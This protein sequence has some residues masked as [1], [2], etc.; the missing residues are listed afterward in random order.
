MN[1]QLER[2]T[3][4]KKFVLQ[5]LLE[6]YHYDSSEYND[7]KLNEFGLFGYKYLDHYWTEE[8][9]HPFFI[10]CDDQLAG[11]VLVRIFSENE[12]IIHSIAEFFVMRKFRRKGIGKIAAFM[13][14]DQFSGI[15]NVGQEPQNVRAQRFWRTIIKQYSNNH[16]TE[17]QKKYWDGPMQEFIS[18]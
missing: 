9:R 5:N 14:F 2:I 18:K 4:E 7:D 13:V 8:G 10:K 1:I 6:L 15:W 11:F 16:F 12:R 17:I 3:Y